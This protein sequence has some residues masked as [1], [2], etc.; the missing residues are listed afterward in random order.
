[1]KLEKYS[2]GTGDRFAHQGE[3]QLRAL[4]MAKDKGLDIVPVWNK[5]NREHKI[6]KSVPSDTRSAADKAVKA[7]NWKDNYYVDADH[8]NLANV[9]AFIEPCNFFTIDVAE[10]ISKPVTKEEVKNFIEIHSSFVGKMNI[11]GIEKD[12]LITPQL[13]ENI[14]IKFLAAIKEAGKIYKYIQKKK[15][16]GNF[17]AEVSID[18][19]NE[20]QS[21]LELLFILSALANEGV[22]LQTIAP[23]FTGRFNKGVNYQGNIEKFGEEF[24]EDLAVISFAVR[25]FN[26]PDNLKLSVHSGSDKFSIYPVIKEKIRKYDS[27]LHI[28][29]AGTTWLEELAGLAMGGGEGLELAKEIYASSY[30]RYDELCVPY[31]T[32]LNIDKS[33][34]PDPSE[35]KNWSSDEFTDSLRHNLSRDSYNPNFRQLLH[36]SYKI[37]AEMGEIYLHNIIKY[38]DIISRNVTENLYEKHIKPIFGLK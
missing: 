32:V 13:F 19:C 8:I 17:I 7:L 10:H 29:T 14:A 12:F 37:A 6:V 23:K 38:K 26:L 22:Q 24:D 9:D 31:S 27:G 1:M 36:C 3:A 21:P 5:S 28:K 2:F 20:S 15:G 18:E 16:K 34:L 30:L 33:L 25:T 35:V 4:M 11:P